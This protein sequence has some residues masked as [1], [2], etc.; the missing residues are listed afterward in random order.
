ML[1]IV[2]SAIPDCSATSALDSPFALLRPLILS[3]ILMSVAGIMSLLWADPCSVLVTYRLNSC[4]FARNQSAKGTYTPKGGTKKSPGL[5]PVYRCECYTGNH[6][7]KRLA[8]V[9]PIA[10]SA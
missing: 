6:R 10:P 3:P 7:F 4:F 5:F 8:K 9:Q 2:D 1:A